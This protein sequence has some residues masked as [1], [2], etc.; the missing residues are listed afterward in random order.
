MTRPVRFLIPIVIA[1]VLGP[2][3]ASLAFW[4]F[5]IAGSL[6]NPSASLPIAD[7]FKML[8]VYI[9][10][11]YVFGGAIALLA[12]ILVSIWTI[13][14]PPTL[15]VVIAAAVVATAIY[16]GLGALGFMGPAEVTNA[17]ANFLLIF[18]LAVIA[19]IGCWLLMR[20]FVP[21]S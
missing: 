7:L 13:S 4:V 21:A 18:A 12:G 11:A 19:A 16:L 8:G 5:A 9:V 6:F 17:R 1:V 20:R 15:I 3:I 2:L 14:R 10:F